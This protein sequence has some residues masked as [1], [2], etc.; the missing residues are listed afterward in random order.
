MHSQLIKIGTSCA[1]AAGQDE[2]RYVGKGS[3]ATTEKEVRHGRRGGVTKK[4]RVKQFQVKKTRPSSFGVYHHRPGLD[5]RN[6]DR[7]RYLSSFS[8]E[9]T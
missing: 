1:A 5:M 2:R 6:E 8:D 7:C 9:W 3:A 4:A